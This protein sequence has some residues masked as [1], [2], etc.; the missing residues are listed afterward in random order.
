MCIDIILKGLKELI[1]SFFF[2]LYISLFKKT[3]RILKGATVVKRALGDTNLN[4]VVIKG[5]NL[6]KKFKKFI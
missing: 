6:S 3:L 1:D 4:D 5:N 2:P